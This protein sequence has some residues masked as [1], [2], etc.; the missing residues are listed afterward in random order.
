MC[1]MSSEEARAVA[2][3]ARDPNE[4][5]ARRRRAVARGRVLHAVAMRRVLR[6]AAGWVAWLIRT[7]VLAPL[8]HAFRQRS[9]THLLLSMNDRMLADIGL[10]R[11]DVQA[12]AYGL[13]RVDQFAADPM[14]AA[15]PPG[16]DLADLSCERTGDL[17]GRLPQAA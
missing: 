13:V 3:M 4:I 6:E 12:L 7:V 14:E 11:A 2:A 16:G 8:R 5:W 15:S 10:M 9:D 1:R 17:A